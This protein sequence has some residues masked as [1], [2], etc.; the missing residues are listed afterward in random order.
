MDQRLLAEGITFTAGYSR[1]ISKSL[2]KKQ[3]NSITFFVYLG[4]AVTTVTL[5]KVHKEATKMGRSPISS[6]AF[7]KIYWLRI[8]GKEYAIKSQLIKQEDKATLNFKIDE[9]LREFFFYKIASVLQV[10]PYL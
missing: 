7:S 3:G 4:Y 8:N 9:V 10:G 6:G 5:L 2:K 1:H